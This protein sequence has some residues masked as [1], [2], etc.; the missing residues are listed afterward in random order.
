MTLFAALLTAALSAP[1]PLQ[2]HTEGGVTLSAPGSWK[3]LVKAAEHNAVLSR[4]AATHIHLHWW[5]YKEGASADRMLDKLI[6]VTGANL[7]LG[8]IQ[9]RERSTVLDGQGR[10]ATADFSKFGYTMKLAFLVVMDAP[11]KAIKGAILLTT[12]E[13]WTELDAPA[14]IASVTAALQPPAP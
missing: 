13:G 14:L 4:D 12:P 1:P 3:V 7:P 11:H 9:E 8:Q 5:P 10:L 2:A 6:S